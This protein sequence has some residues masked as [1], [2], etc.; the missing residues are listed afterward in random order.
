VV[1]HR[2]TLADALDVT[3]ELLRSKHG[4]AGAYLPLVFISCVEIIDEMNIGSV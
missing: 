3:P 2:E 4:D 1:R